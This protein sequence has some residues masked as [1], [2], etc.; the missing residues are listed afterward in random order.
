MDDLQAFMNENAV[1]CK[2][3][4]GDFML[5]DNMMSYHSRQTF[6]TDGRRKVVASIAKGTK[7]VTVK[8]AHLT[9]SSGDRM[10]SVGLGTW[11]IGKDVTA[12]VCYNAIKNGYRLIDEACDYGNEVEAGEGINRAISEGLV[13]RDDLFVTSKLWN[14][15]HRKEHVKAACLKT[16]AD[17]K[18]DYLDLYL[19]HFPISLKFVPFEKRY[20]P[21]WIYDPE[22]RDARMVED[23]VPMRETWEAM[24]ELVEEGLVRNI[25]LC[26]VGVSMLRDILSYATIKPAVLQVEMHPYNSQEMLLKFCRKNGISVTAFSNLGASSY[27]E[28]GMA[29]KP[30][31]CLEEACIVEMGKKYGKTPAQIVLRWAVQR[32]TAIV[33]KSSKTARLVENISLFEF[34]IS[35]DDMDTISTLNKNK[36]FNDPGNFAQAAFNTFY[37]IYE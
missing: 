8:P 22:S 9:L 13:K 12:D 4:A 23:L 30:E 7:E 16:L 17:L 24:Q 26:N 35:A 28:L 19:I 33:P 25:G 31:S 3:H 37:P 2:W 34:N 15:Y 27:F 36:R 29:T 21:E 5:I 6:S 11:K 14:T 20:P 32:G 10:P 18:L 1:A